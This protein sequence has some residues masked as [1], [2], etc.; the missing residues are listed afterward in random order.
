MDLLRW[1]GW[2]IHRSHFKGKPT[3]QSLFPLAGDKTSKKG[4]PQKL[5]KDKFLSLVKQLKNPDKSWQPQ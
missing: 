2:S 4:K 3:R 5:N 1:V